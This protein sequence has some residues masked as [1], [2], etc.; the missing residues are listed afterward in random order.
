MNATVYFEIMQ[1][2]VGPLT[3]V[4]DGQALTQVLFGERRPSNAV[5]GHALLE[6]T[7]RQLDDYFAGRRYVFDLPLN[8]QGTRFRQSVWRALR[9]IPFAETRSYA[10]IA[11]AIGKPKASRAVGA[12]NGANPLAIIVPCHR[13]IGANGALVGY[14][15]GME[16][17]RRLLEHEREAAARHARADAA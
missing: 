12:A 17:K 7:R 13:V 14:G 4:C 10:E 16:R 5:H 11:A 15:G 3:L 9:D 2:P 1:S 6:E 8:A